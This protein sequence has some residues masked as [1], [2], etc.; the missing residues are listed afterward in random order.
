MFLTLHDLGA[1]R[2]A[3]DTHGRL[4]ARVVLDA[5]H[6]V[7]LPA[8]A[9]SLRSRG[10]GTAVGTLAARAGP[11]RVLLFFWSRSGRYTKVTV[12]RENLGHLGLD[13]ACAKKRSEN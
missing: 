9:S 4:G 6:S 5:G 3:C 13:L 2:V 10:R 11:T 12:K 8:A 7:R 1:P